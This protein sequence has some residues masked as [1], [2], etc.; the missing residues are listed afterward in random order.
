MKSPNLV[1]D[2]PKLIKA[3]SASSA[4]PFM[5]SRVRLKKNQGTKDRLDLSQIAFLLSLLLIKDPKHKVKSDQKSACPTMNRGC[6]RSSS[7]F[8]SKLENLEG[9][10]CPRPIL[11]QSILRPFRYGATQ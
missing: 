9:A 8:L 7:L 3:A 6:S 1:G 11:S 4:R 5:A 2:G 10:G